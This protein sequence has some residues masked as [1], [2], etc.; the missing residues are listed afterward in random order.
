[1]T[2]HTSYLG[3]LQ[4]YIENW[5]LTHLASDN[6]GYNEDLVRKF[7]NGFPQEDSL[8]CREL[9]VKVCGKRGLARKSFVISLGCLSPWGITKLPTIVGIH[10]SHVIDMAYEIYSFYRSQT[11]KKIKVGGLKDFYRTF[12]HFVRHNILLNTQN[13]EVPMEG[14][15]HV[16]PWWFLVKVAWTQRL[17]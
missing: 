15:R 4:D 9:T 5:S 8:D 12:W 10:Q 14:C 6:N 1:M 2:S 17:G 16:V 3:A 13:W 7:C 11:S